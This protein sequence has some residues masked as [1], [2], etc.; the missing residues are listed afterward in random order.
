VGA[1]RTRNGFAGV[2]YSVVDDVEAVYREISGRGIKPPEGSS[3][4]A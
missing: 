2:A 1:H 3:D 4:T